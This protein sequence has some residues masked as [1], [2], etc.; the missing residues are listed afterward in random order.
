M[1]CVV[2]WEGIQR[3]RALIFFFPAS[4]DAELNV[5]SDDEDV[6]LEDT[7]EHTD[8]IHPDMVSKQSSS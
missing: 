6:D 3:E 2:I 7:Q 1:V 8:D 4:P 5:S